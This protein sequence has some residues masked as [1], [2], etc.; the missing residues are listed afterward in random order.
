MIAVPLKAILWNVRGWASKETEMRNRSTCMDIGL[1]TELK[2]KRGNIVSLPGFEV[3]IENRYNDGRG[4][5][6]AAIFIRKGIKREYLKFEQNKKDFDVCGI[7]LAG[8][9][10]ALNIICVYRR[11]GSQ[12]KK[13]AWKDIL[14]HVDTNEAVIIGGDFNAHHLVWNCEKTDSVGEVLLEEFESKDL[15]VVNDDTKNEDERS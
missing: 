15:F 14:R 9:V 7:R 11:P 2:N 8:K 5:G 1:F 10:G 13:G 6:G 3:A 4:A 12:V